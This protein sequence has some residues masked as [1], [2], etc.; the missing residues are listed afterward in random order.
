MKNATNDNE[1]FSFQSLAAVT[2]GL[3]GPREPGRIHDEADHQ[4]VIS[5][6]HREPSERAEQQCERSE[7]ERAS[8][9][10][11]ERDNAEHGAYVEQR[12]RELAAFERRA[13][14]ELPARR[15]RR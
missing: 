7:Q 6:R 9:H 3:L 11:N 13:N 5:E 2:A 12:L 14:G 1:P 4:R 15:R 10:D 8:R